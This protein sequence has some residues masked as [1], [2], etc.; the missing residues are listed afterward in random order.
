MKAWLCLNPVRLKVQDVYGKWAET[1]CPP[2]AL[3]MLA[4]YKYK[5]TGREIHG[6][7]ARFAQIDWTT[8]VKEPA[9]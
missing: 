6:K 1:K 3:A 5:K 8:P 2:E 9:Q 7:R 4:V